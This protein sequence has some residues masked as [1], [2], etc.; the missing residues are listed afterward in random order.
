MGT[1]RATRLEDRHQGMKNIR[2]HVREIAL[3]KDG[4]WEAQLLGGFVQICTAKPRAGRNA[5]LEGEAGVGE[6]NREAVGVP[7]GFLDAETKGE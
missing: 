5:E 6:R 4:C 7:H 1:E 3:R 2:Y